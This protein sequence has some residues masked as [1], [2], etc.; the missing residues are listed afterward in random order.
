[1]TEKSAVRDYTSILYVEKKSPS[2]GQEITAFCN[3]GLF[4]HENY[5][6]WKPRSEKDRCL[7]GWGS[8]PQFSQRIY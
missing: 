3:N 2:E 4:R 8:S 1:M 6:L 7:G 5:F